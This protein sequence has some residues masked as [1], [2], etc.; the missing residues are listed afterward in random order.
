MQNM[1][2]LNSLLT[3]IKMPRMVKIRQRFAKESIEDVAASVKQEFSKSDIGMRVKAGMQIAITV[4]SRGLDKLPILVKAIVDEVKERGAEPFIVPS[5]GSH[6]GATAEGQKNVLKNL[7]IT[8]A[9]MG[10][11]IRSGMEV[12]EVG[13]LPNGL[14]VLIDKYAYE[15]DGIILLNRVKPH[16]A[17]RGPCESGLAKMLSI[18]LGNQKGADSCHAYTFTHMAEF[19]V[20]MAKIKIANTKVLF[21][22]ATIEN[23]YDKV[24]KVIG[25]PAEQILDIE[26]KLLEQAKSLMPQ[27]LFDKIDVLIVEEIG[28]EISGGGMDGNVTGRYAMSG[29]SGG[30]SVDKIALLRLSEKTHGNANGMGIADTTTK[31]VLDEIDYESTYINC[32]TTMLST[33]CKV[34]MVLANDQLA[35]AA[36][37][38]LSLNQDVNELKMVRILDTLHLEE[39]YIS[40]ALLPTAASNSAVEIVGE[41]E[42]FCFDANGNIVKF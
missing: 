42:E 32:I 18:G 33:P 26:P 9:S 40:E 27:I 3:D 7:G 16:T 30:P 21:G 39:I 6:G 15:A 28:K 22:I 41:A 10:C 23:A 35:I 20:E 34:P 11:D 19:V 4:G 38:K 29:L 5:M 1:S 24:A 36:A 2:V 37:I 8:E 17:F 25:V 14:A 13:R 12:V 31:R